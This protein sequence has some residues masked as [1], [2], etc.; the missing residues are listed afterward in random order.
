M[1]NKVFQMNDQAVFMI[2]ELGGHMPGGFFI[3]KA[4][5]P[6]ELLYAKN[7]YLHGVAANPLVSKRKDLYTA[8]FSTF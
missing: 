8:A 3:Y 7:P 2:R 5:E 1:A 6:G 4:E